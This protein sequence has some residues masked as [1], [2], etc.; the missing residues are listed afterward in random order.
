MWFAGRNHLESL[1]GIET[2]KLADT[3]MSIE[4]RNH[5]ESLS[6]IETERWHELANMPD[7]VEITLNPFQGLKPKLPD[8]IIRDSSCRNHLESLSGI[9]TCF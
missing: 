8:D 9:E 6:G 2:E 7:F 3:Q 1:S 4:G 5:L